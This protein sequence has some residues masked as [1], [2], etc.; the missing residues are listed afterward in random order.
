MQTGMITIG[1]RQVGWRCRDG[2]VRSFGAD[3]GGD[4]AHVDEL[5]QEFGQERGQ[6]DAS[7]AKSRHG[8]RYLG[9][10]AYQ[11]C[12]AH[13]DFSAVVLLL[14]QVV[15]EQYFSNPSEP[16][17]IILV[18]T[19][20]PDTVAWQFR[21][22]DTCWLAEL[23]AGAIQ[24][25]YPHVTVKV[26]VCNQP[27]NSIENLRQ[28]VGQQ[29]QQYYQY[30]LQNNLLENWSL[31][32]QIKGS[33]PQLSS[34]VE[35]MAVL[36]M[37][38]FPVSHLIP[39]EPIPF[40]APSTQSAQ[41]A[42][43][44][45]KVHLGEVFWPLEQQRIEMAWQQGHFVAAT[46]LLESHRDRYEALYQLADR[47]AMAT[48]WQITEMLKQLQ[49]AHWVYHRA[50]KQV[51]SKQQRQQ[52][53][54]AIQE[55]CPPRAETRESKFLKIWELELLIELSLRQQ[56]YTF[57]FMQFAQMLER[58]LHWRYETEEWAK[59]GY[60]N[61]EQHSPPQATMWQPDPGLGS[62]WNA[63][64]KCHHCSDDDPRVT[65]LKTINQKRNSVVHRNASITCKEL[66]QI[67][68]V[69]RDAP[70]ELH[71]GLVEFLEAIAQPHPR[72]EAGVA[73]SLYGWG[74]GQL[75]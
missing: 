25:R 47:L 42:T 54:Q 20:Q 8:V 48:N 27:I 14:D 17:E 40:F 50:T 49:G 38:R 18:G 67:A 65:T 37:R 45:K 5:F 19:D 64:K 58:L 4:P 24:Q 66:Q 52:W 39:E 6:H 46:F 68:A 74:L 2:I 30:L 23:M 34:A 12:T 1:K 15:L 53:Q 72:P 31:H 21:R 16:A 44:L 32:L 22:D 13:Q 56:N 28:W 75:R 55:R 11:Y 3:G 7:D 59:Q 69:S 61:S 71:R 41:S 35:L 70:E 43:T 29:L 33:V 10:F 36:A 9:E 57:A 26:W 62:L 51:A 73:R 60:L 63:W